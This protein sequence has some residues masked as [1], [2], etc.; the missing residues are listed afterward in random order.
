MKTLMFYSY[1]GGSGRTVA[2]AN[3]SAALTKLGQRVAIIDLD[4]EAP[5][6]QHV[7]SAEGTQQF[8]NGTGVQHYLKSEIDVHELMSDVAIDVFAEGGPL[9][10][11]DVPKGAL[12]RYIMASTK[13]TRVDAQDPRVPQLMKQ[14]VAKLRETYDLDYL[15]IDAASGIRETYSL[16]ADVSNE[17]LVFFRWSTQHVEGT[18]R[19][20]RYMSRLKEFE[21]SWVPFRLV[22]S[23]SP[24]SEE[25]ERL[26]DHELRE[27]LLKIKNNTQA[28]IEKTLEECQATP[29]TIFH[30]IPEM[31]ELKWRETITVFANDDTP[32]ERLAQMILDPPK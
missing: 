4:F 14:L 32:Y 12:L 11:Y 22:A 13:V 8:K 20:V 30:E 23:A 26:S 6:L 1:K 25:I 18:L 10:K 15:I 3:V 19:L 2:A 9:F 7:F 24:G 21:Q 17:M 27:D 5:G 29:A 28:R 16:A 31:L